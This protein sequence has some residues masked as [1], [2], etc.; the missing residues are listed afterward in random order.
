M[1][2]DAETTVLE[3][4][5]ARKF[6]GSLSNWQIAGHAFLPKDSECYELKLMMFPRHS[7]FMRK[8]KNSQCYYTVFSKR[9][10]EDNR[11][12]YLNPVGYGRLPRD[13]KTQLEVG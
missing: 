1:F 6:E 4:V 3:I 11:A 7:Y 12:K 8:N 2:S 9:I 5:T 13:M 10:W